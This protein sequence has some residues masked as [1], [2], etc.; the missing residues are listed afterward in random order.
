MESRRLNRP[1]PKPTS[2]TQ[3]KHIN[4]GVATI[5]SPTSPA[6]PIA[7]V[8]TDVISARI[9]AIINNTPFTLRELQTGRRNYRMDKRRLNKP[10]PRPTRGT[11]TNRSS[12]GVPTMVVPTVPAHV[13]ALE[14]MEPI[15]VR[16]VAI[17]TVSV[18]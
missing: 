14:K 9:A 5:V 16:I 10:T 4:R 11:T 15:E 12:S 18:K 7:A 8:N 17:V 3:T 2:G 1:T 6:Q 13:M